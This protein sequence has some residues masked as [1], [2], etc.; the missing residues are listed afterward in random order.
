MRGLFI[1][2][3][4]IKYD[5]LILGQGREQRLKPLI[6]LKMNTIEKC[7]AAGIFAISHQLLT[8]LHRKKSVTKLFGGTQNGDRELWEERGEGGSFYNPHSQESVTKKIWTTLENAFS[9]NIVQEHYDRFNDL[10]QYIVSSKL[11]V[12]EIHLV[13][14][15]IEEVGIIPITFELSLKQKTNVDFHQY[16]IPLT[17]TVIVLL[18]LPIWKEMYLKMI[19]I[20]FA[21]I[22]I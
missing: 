20:S 6:L 5:I 21:E 4:I 15:S 9:Q 8:V 3:N 10:V 16:F 19:M 18:K 2:T 17:K 1:L 11:S 12:P 13:I 14:E 22:L 7:F